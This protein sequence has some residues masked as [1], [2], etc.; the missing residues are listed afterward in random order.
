MSLSDVSIRN[1]V[2]AW[3]LMASLVIFGAVSF[4]NL[5][6]SQLP[7]VDFP[8]VNINVTLE[9]A[10]PEVIEA[11]VIDPIE[12]AVTTVQGIN[13]INS[14][15]R[16]GS[17]S[18]SVEFSL[19]KN[20]DVAVQELQSAL[21]LVQRVLPKGTEPPVIQK[22]NPDSQPILWLGLSSE[23]MNL[24][25]LM[26]FTRD[27]VKDQFGTI[28][29]VGD[30]FLGGYVDP[31]LRVYVSR[32]KLNQLALTPSDVVASIQAEHVELPSG[33]IETPEKELN[34]R[35][36]GEATDLRSFGDLIISRRGGA[37]N[38]VP[39]KISDVAQVE[40]GLSDVRRISRSNGK[41]A[42][43][44]GI[45]KQPGVNAVDVARRVKVKME[46]VQKT[47]PE[48][49]QLSMRFDSTVF[50]KEAAD[51]LT[52]TLVLSALLTALVCWL[53]LGSW[54]ATLNVVLAIPTSVLGTF[55]VLSALDFTL[56]TFTL[57]AL[58]LA[59]GIVV[60]DAIM[61]LENIIRHSEMGKDKVRAS[62]DGAREIT[63]AALA[64]TA[65]IIAIFLPVAFMSGIIGK[66]FF[67]FG[68]TLSV[69]VAVSL[70]EALTLTPMRTSQF[71]AP[72]G[73][74][75]RIG[76]AFESG[77]HALSAAYGRWIP[78]LIAHPW[79]TV[80]ISLL[81]FVLSF[82]LVAPLKKEFSPAQD[83]GTVLIRIQA[84]VGTSI[85]ATDKIFAEIEKV[86]MAYPESEGYFGSVGGFGGGD[87][88]TAIIFLRLKPKEQRTRSAQT[89]M[90]AMRADF[91]GFKAA[92]V[93]IQDT[94]LNGFGGGRGFP[95]E[96]S[97]KGPEFGVLTEVSSRIMKS[98]ES[99]GLMSDVDSSFRE[100]MPEVHVVPDRLKAQARAVSISEIANT[101][102]VLMGGTIAGRYVKG[103]RRQDIRVSI[104][105]EEAVDWRELGKILVRNNRGE[106]VPL[107]QVV[108]V[109]EGTGLQ[110]ITRM[111]RERSVTLYA[112]LAKGK[113]QAEAMA[114]VD[115]ITQKELPSGYHL[116]VSGSAKTF[117]ESF[118]SLM[119][120]ILLG[121]L[122]SYMILA[123]QFNSYV[124][125]VTVLIA[126]PFSVSGAFIGLF[127][128][129]QSLN[130]YSFIGLI[131]LM[132]I[133]KKNSILLV[134][135][136]NQLRRAGEDVRSAIQKACP[137]R[138]RPIIM[139]SVSTIV[140]AIPP[141]LALGP[142]A[143]TRV[144]MAIAVIGGVLVST[145]LTLVV[146][147]CVYLLFSKVQRE[148]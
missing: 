123:A 17:G 146:V 148:I 118:Q 136:T 48:G 30:V 70:L 138:L 65:A 104:A 55:I 115:K 2:F 24:R 111:D 38:Y 135:M 109:K 96:F 129:G 103:G 68:V 119:M 45:R 21:S 105:R 133:V 16:A 13:S 59:I 71:L 67:Q 29:G 98:M 143:E 40:D 142:G 47:L 25:D 32:T 87:V 35:T 15:A 145:L 49:M 127:V 61:V 22:F 82:G 8:F 106:L 63:F 43:G 134:E 26:R 78:R 113:T 69:S 34:I 4:V 116:A 83:Q 51:E 108:T 53:F 12:S 20:I 72:P 56:N 144:P 125:P 6:V 23:K 124:H 94:S 126:L 19:D 64:A 11:D 5:G 50:I 120:A 31:A 52:M 117:K 79:K 128:S 76:R 75:T 3:M 147:P 88:N 60:D 57:L 84:P 9:G 10:A 121:I 36:L 114:A 74:R 102:N 91:K 97:I 99:S 46:E 27:R 141:A 58:S 54:S 37:P 101:I 33:R 131:L 100:G 130:M 44:L 66:F 14:T 140:A 110:S 18:I 137:I 80:F 85:Q 92:K 112:N 28:Q 107:S 81:F 139:T 7:D 1:P 62:S 122:V 39:L 86:V 90:E 77:M 132:G 41:P 95:V 93:V 89:L 42:V 73:H